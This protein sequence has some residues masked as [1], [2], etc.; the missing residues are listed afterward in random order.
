MA[1]ATGG[2]VQASRMAAAIKR[3]TTK[4]SQPNAINALIAPQERYGAL[5]I[6]QRTR[7]KFGFVVSIPKAAK[8]KLRISEASRLYQRPLRTK[9]LCIAIWLSKR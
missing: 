1:V 9:A 4:A 5:M 3:M 7:A 8:T 2:V 6:N